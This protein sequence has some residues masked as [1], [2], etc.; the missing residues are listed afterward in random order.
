MGIA[1]VEKKTGGMAE[2]LLFCLLIIQP[3]LDV[4]SYW[5]TVYKL[6][7]ITTTVRMFLLAACAVY[8]FLLSR[9]KKIYLAAAA[10]MAACFAGHLAAAAAG[11]CSDYLSDVSNF[12]RVIH[13]PVLTLCFITV[14]RR[15]RDVPQKIQL[16]FFVNLLTILA[17][18][19]LSCT[20]GPRNY[21]Y[22]YHR[23]GLIGWTAVDN[24]QSAV[25]TLIV[26]LI[27]VFAY[28][29]NRPLLFLLCAVL[30]F[31]QLF[32]LG[33][34]LALYSIFIIAGGM[35]AIL[36]VCREKRRVWYLV[37]AGVMLCTALCCRLSPNYAYGQS[38][39][40][41]AQERQEW[42]EQTFDGV[43]PADSFDAMT[44]AQYDAYN[45]VYSAYL[46][47]LVQRFG[48]ERA[49]EAYD[50]TLDPE[51]LNNNRTK[52]LLFCGFA[53]DESGT[54]AHL[55]G[56]SYDQMLYQ[57]EVFDPENDFNALVYTTGY[58]GTALY[59][60]FLLY[61]AALIVKGL[62]TDFKGVFSV[63]AGAVGITLCLILGAAQFSGN[64]LRRPNV[65]IYLSLMLAY[66]YWL[67]A[68]R[69]GIRLF[70]KK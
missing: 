46:G 45:T 47:G 10:V 18:L 32:F 14:F 31:G 13:M 52:K 2:R 43:E 64:V 67:T 37:L 6:T 68:G 9:R 24:C 62:L 3:V 41:V 50:Y 57:D 63:E 1:L 22:D 55:F 8:G 28:R 19:L 12:M 5:T 65:S 66:A 51:I 56:M 58:V 35:A 38:H 25:V 48:L 4:A 7:A 60:L 11:D 27:L 23:I 36:A 15:G 59:V 39:E 61:F 44:P 33:T 21:T 17:V 30:C 70:E 53:W 16:A 29:K 69:R 42:V 49:L 26:P 54:L 20:V 40:K 34:R